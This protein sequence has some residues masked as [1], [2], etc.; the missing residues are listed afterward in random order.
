MNPLEILD[1]VPNPWNARFLTLIVTASIV[2]TLF[3]SLRTGGDRLAGGGVA[4]VLCV[5]VIWGWQKYGKSAQAS[6]GASRFIR[7]V[8]APLLLGVPPMVTAILMG[9]AGA[10]GYP[11]SLAVLFGFVLFATRDLEQRARADAGDDDEH[12]VHLLY[13][14]FLAMISTAFFFFGVL[15]LWPW[16]GKLYGIEYFWILV[17]GVLSPTL[18]LWN[19]LRQPHHHS[20]MTALVRF[21]RVVPYL[22][23]VLAIAIL[24]G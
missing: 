7:L 5:I 15:T 3:A 1:R 9:N 24:I 16:L 14:S 22:G 19:K 17:L 20:S 11:A 2:A 23:L 12:P 10:G 8:V 13:R 6:L 18:Y 4:L 21:N